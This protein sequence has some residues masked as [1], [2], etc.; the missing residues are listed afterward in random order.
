M[1]E[2]SRKTKKKKKKKRNSRSVKENNFIGP[3]T[4]KFLIN[5][6]LIK[7]ICILSSKYW[8]N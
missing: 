5:S 6:S 7:N 2:I 4:T 1:I 8:V 3:S